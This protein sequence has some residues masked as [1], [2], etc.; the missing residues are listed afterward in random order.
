MSQLNPPITTRM[1]LLSDRSV[2]E[3]GQ[4]REW[5]RATDDFNLRF[6]SDEANHVA[7]PLFFCLGPSD[8]SSVCVSARYSLTRGHQSLVST[9]HTKHWQLGE[10]FTKNQWEHKELTF[11]SVNSSASPFYM[12]NNYKSCC[13]SVCLFFFPYSSNRRAVVSNEC[14]HWIYYSGSA[15]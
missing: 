11:V 7:C 10:I 6:D 4:Q 15:K 13:Y 8:G 1:D 3:L 9:S 5:V 2:L 12:E 14:G